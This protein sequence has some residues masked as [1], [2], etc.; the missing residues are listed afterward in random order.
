MVTCLPCFSSSHNDDEDRQ[1]L[2]QDEPEFQP[3]PSAPSRPPLNKFAD[4]LSALRSGK[5]PSQTQINQLLQHVLRL[6]L[7]QSTRDPESAATPEVLR[8]DGPLSTSGRRVIQD[9]EE[10]IQ[11]VLQ[12]GMEKNGTASFIIL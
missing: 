7:L 6:E 12:F 1:P 4:I 2:L 9:L 8:G 5:L 3:P 10:V 11:A